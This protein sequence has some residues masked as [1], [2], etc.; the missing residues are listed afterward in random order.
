MYLVV[1]V[2]DRLDSCI[3][4]KQTE[5]CLNWENE[6]FSVLAFILELTF[7]SWNQISKPRWNR[8]TVKSTASTEGQSCLNNFNLK[9]HRTVL[10]LQFDSSVLK[11]LQQR[12]RQTSG[13]RGCGPDHRRGVR[14]GRWRGGG[15]DYHRGRR[16][17]Y[18][19][20]KR[21]GGPGLSGH[22]GDGGKTGGGTSRGGGHADGFTWNT[23][24]RD[25][26]CDT[27][28]IINNIC[29]YLKKTP[30]WVL[31]ELWV[32]IFVVFITCYKWPLGTSLGCEAVLLQWLRYWTSCDHHVTMI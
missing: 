29:Q 19:G 22:E 10:Q 8:W 24:G 12:L 26:I 13:R 2:V 6:S 28:Y 23:R 20:R 25:I 21:W 16:R 5:K 14:D 17:G 1:D 9:T 3:L 31:E 30:E 7:V 27:H 18:G 11:V 32:F 4:R 15:L